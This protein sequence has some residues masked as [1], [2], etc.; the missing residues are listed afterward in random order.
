M[1]K[2]LKWSF[3]MSEM[4]RTFFLKSVIALWHEIDAPRS[5]KEEK[6]KMYSQLNYRK[7]YPL[8]ARHGSTTSQTTSLQ[9]CYA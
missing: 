8:V 2:R 9:L 3:Y 5:K 6:S 4:T 1:L 7:C